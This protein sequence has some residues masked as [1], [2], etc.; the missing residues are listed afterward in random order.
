[1]SNFLK[2]IALTIAIILISGLIF[3]L[4]SIFSKGFP[5]SEAF[6]NA[7]YNIA[8]LVFYGQAILQVFLIAVI[9]KVVK[10]LNFMLLISIVTFSSFV[11]FSIFFGG[12]KSAS[13][14][15]FPF[16]NRV[17]SVRGLFC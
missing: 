4:H 5:L 12:F 17:P 15:F 3:G 14:L 9:Y 2:S 1:M 8:F 6:V 11:S 13:K 10:N 7:G 16:L